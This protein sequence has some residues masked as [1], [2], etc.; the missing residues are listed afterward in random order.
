VPSETDKNAGS[1]KYGTCC[2]EMDIWE[3]NSEGAAYTPHPCTQNG[4]CEG[5][6]CGDADQRHEG[7]CDKDGCDYS[8]FRLG[9]RSYYGPGKKVDTKKPITVITQFVTDT[10]TDSG[11]LKEIRRLYV[12]GGKLIQNSKVNMDGVD[13]YDSITDQFCADYKVPIGDPDTFKAKGGMKKMSDEMKKGMVLVMSIW[14]DHAAHMLWLDSSYP[15]DKD[16]EA[17][18][19][20][21]GECP[22]D[23]GDPADVESQSPKASVKYSD[24]KLGPIGSTYKAT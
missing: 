13:E 9:D 8:H 20:M 3:A 10:G 19:V 21:R 4:R 23:S 6:N 24:I 22:T 16:P 7:W 11:T 5:T 17:P 12:Q 2:T 18:G 15:L 1:G 14:D